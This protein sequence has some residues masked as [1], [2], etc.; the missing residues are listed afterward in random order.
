MAQE[1]LVGACY[2]VWK[3]FSLI[4]AL[5]AYLRIELGLYIYYI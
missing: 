3:L 1:C 4:N 2:D 5:L